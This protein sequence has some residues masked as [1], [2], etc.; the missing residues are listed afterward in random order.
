M[1]VFVAVE[2]TVRCMTIN[3]RIF[4][5]GS[6]GDSLAYHRGFQFSRKDRDNVRSQHNCAS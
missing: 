5:T 6:A 4:L 2:V 1:L 3:P